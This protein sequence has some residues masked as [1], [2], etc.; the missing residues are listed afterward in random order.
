MPEKAN[1][2]AS[3]QT[4]FWRWS[5]IR[6]HVAVSP[7]IC[8][9]AVRRLDQPSAARAWEIASQNPFPSSTRA[10]HESRSGHVSEACCSTT[11]GRQPD[12]AHRTFRTLRPALVRKAQSGLE[13]LASHDTLL[14]LYTF[15]ANCK[16][17][18]LAI[19]ERVMGKQ[20]LAL[21]TPDESQS[22]EADLIEAA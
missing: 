11:I 10:T 8:S 2:I 9:C 5:S 4:V 15:Y 21:P 18:L 7:S 17:K 12:I 22:E 6:R 16:L 19:I 14:C 13:T 1:D 20:R 3:D